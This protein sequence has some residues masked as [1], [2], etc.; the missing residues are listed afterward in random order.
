MIEAENDFYFPQKQ[1]GQLSPYLGSSV[2]VGRE[3]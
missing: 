1:Y 2:P 3:T